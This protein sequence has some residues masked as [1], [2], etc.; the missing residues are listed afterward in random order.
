MNITLWQQQ[1][2][3]A[4]RSVV[5]VLSRYWQKCVAVVRSFVVRGSCSCGDASRLTSPRSSLPDWK[6]SHASLYEYYR[7]LVMMREPWRVWFMQRPVQ[8]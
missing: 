6:R 2:I 7:R 3:Q 1:M 5:T 8:I 4:F